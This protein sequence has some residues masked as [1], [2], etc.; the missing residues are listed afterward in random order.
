MIEDNPA[1]ATFAEIQ[2]KKAFVEQAY[3]QKCEYF[4]KASQLI[5]KTDFQVI[6][7]DLCLP[8]SKGLETL[9]AFLKICKS[10]VVIYTGISDPLVINEAKSSGAMDFLVKGK[11]TVADLKQSILKSIKEY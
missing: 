4:L 1:D 2:L 5:E 8:D 10:P 6:L 11:T 7:L 3:I 9:K